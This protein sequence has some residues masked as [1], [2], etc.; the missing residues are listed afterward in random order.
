MQYASAIIFF[1]IV[2]CSATFVGNVMLIQTTAQGEDEESQS[3]LDFTGLITDVSAFI[4]IGFVG[5]MAT[6]VNGWI[7]GNKEWK[8]S[9]E[10]KFDTQDKRMITL[11]NETKNNS[12]KLNT[13]IELLVSDFKGFKEIYMREMSEISNDY[14]ALSTVVTENRVEIKQNKESIR[15]LKQDIKELKK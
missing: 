14:D 9:I 6:R 1:V 15:D 2:C 10:A 13:A 5:Y 3:W 11:E 4:V 7:K 8:E 12:Q